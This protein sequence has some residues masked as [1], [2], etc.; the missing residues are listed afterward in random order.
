MENRQNI[1][2]ILHDFANCMRLSKLLKAVKKIFKEMGTPKNLNCDQEFVQS[3]VLKDYFEGQRIK[4]HVSDTDEINKNA[5]IE[6]FH[7]TLAL[8]MKRWRD[9]S[10]KNRKWYSVLDEILKNYNTSY[11]RT[12]KTTP[13]KIWRGEDQNHQAPIY[14]HESEIKIGD[15]VRVKQLKTIFGKG[16]ALKYSKE[17]Y[18][19]V[20][21][22]K[23]KE[24]KYQLK[25]IKTNEILKKPREFWKDYEL[26]KVNAIVETQDEEEEEPV[27]EAPRPTKKQKQELKNICDNLSKLILLL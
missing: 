17:I 12:I 6:R 1:K 24:K 11:H 18:S 5:I 27:K 4:L 19:V 25:D 15:L 23:G 9:A 3:K 10:A 14:T 22:R 13:D 20:D 8:L 26:K 2:S 16:D 7:K 21:Q